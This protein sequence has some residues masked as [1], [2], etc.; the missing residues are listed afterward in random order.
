VNAFAL[1]GGFFFVNSGLILKSDN[2][3]ELAGVMAHEIAHVA[4]RHATRNATKSQIWNLISLPMVFVGGPAGMILRQVAG[5]AVPMTFLKFSRDAEREA[6]LLGMQ[7]QYAA[8]YDPTAFVGFFEKLEG[9]E[10]EPHNF[11]ARA[12]MTHPMTDD[13]VRRAEH[14]LENLPDRDSYITD[15]SEFDQVRDRLSKLTRGR[16]LNGGK[17][18]HP[19]LRRRTGTQ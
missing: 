6:D 12:F 14:M 16:A 7:Y 3:P 19:T 9:E 13:R 15:T 8:G 5:V 11:V 1:P 4:A 10:K 17:R 18:P 2:E